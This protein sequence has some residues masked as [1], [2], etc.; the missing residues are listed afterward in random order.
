[1]IQ[2]VVAHEDNRQ[3]R[4][5]CVGPELIIYS[6]EAHVKIAENLVMGGMIIS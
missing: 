5:A 6:E 3:H 2:S 1:M 4:G